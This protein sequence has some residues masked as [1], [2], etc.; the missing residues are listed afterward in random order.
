MTVFL[1]SLFRL[2]MLT[3]VVGGLIVGPVFADAHPAMFGS[4]MATVS[5]QDHAG[6]SC[7][8]TGGRKNP[9]GLAHHPDCCLAGACAV[10]VGIPVATSTAAKGF[11]ACSIA[12]ARSVL[13]EP[14]GIEAVPTTHPPKAAA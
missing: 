6:I 4:S 12:Y 7:D 9:A 3:L 10:S 1:R 2:A 11:D 8:H 5:A 13:A 14:R